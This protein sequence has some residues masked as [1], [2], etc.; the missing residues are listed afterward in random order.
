MLDWYHFIP[1]LSLHTSERYPT[2]FVSRSFLCAI[3]GGHPMLAGGRGGTMKPKKLTTKKSW[4]SCEIFPLLYTSVD[5]KNA[6]TKIK[7][8]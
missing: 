1:I 5:R 4:A 7:T 6:R 2:L 3:N 8:G